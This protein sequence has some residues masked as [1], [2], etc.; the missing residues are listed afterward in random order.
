MNP[1]MSSLMDLVSQ[2]QPHFQTHQALLVIGMQNDFIQPEGRLPVSTKN[3]YLDRIQ[4]LIP[5]FRELNGNVIW[6]QTLYEG[7]R[8]ANDPNTGEGDALV[9]G[10]LVDGDESSTEGGEEDDVL[11]E[12]PTEKMKSP[13]KHKQ[14]ALDLL[15]RVSARR[16]TLPREVARATAEQDDELFLLAS[17]KKTPACV[18]NTHG[19]QFADIIAMQFELPADMVIKTSNYSAFQG[20]SLLMTLR[21]K[22]VTELYIC[23]CI[24]NIS[25]LATVIDAA[26]HGVKINVIED[27]LGYRKKGR[28]ELALK[29][30]DEFFDAYLVNST[31][32]LARERVPVPEK[33]PTSSNGS[34]NGLKDNERL[35]D[36]A[37]GR[38]SLRDAE[39]RPSS[40]PQSIRSPTKILTG[41]ER[42]LSLVSA[43]E[44]RKALNSPLSN[45]Q[46]V[47]PT[48]KEFTD[49]LVRGAIVPGADDGEKEE[50]KLVTKKIRMRSKGTKK[51]KK[52]KIDGDAAPEDVETV[53]VD[54]EAS[55]AVTHGTTE[56]PTPVP[57]TLQAS[58][59]AKSPS[60]PEPEPR[61]GSLLARAESVLNL[62]EKMTKQQPLKS[63]ASQPALSGK[64]DVKEKDK[65]RDSWSD[66][67]RQTLS[68]AP[69]SESDSR[70]R[71][72]YISTKAPSKAESRPESISTPI[73]QVPE[74]SSK[75]IDTTQ[76]E[77]A[78]AGAEEPSVSQES[79]ITASTLSTPTTMTATKT[80]P[81]KLQSLA[82]LPMLGPGDKI[83]EGD[84][85]IL[86]DFIP[87]DLKHPSEPIKPLRDV[88]FT[89][90]Y[91]EV[92]W[93]TMHHQTGAVP[94]LVCAQGLFGTDGS[95]PVY[96]HPSD[97]SLPLLHF[98]PKVEVIRRR[99]EKVVGHPLN[100]VLIQM[101]RDG[102]DYI[103]EHS[104]KTLDIVRG[105]SIVNVSFGAQRTMRL[106]TK[107]SST[108]PASTTDK[109]GEK[110][111]TEEKTRETQ[112]I[113]L[114]HNSIYSLG[115]A[116]NT[117]FLHS[118][119]PDK[120]IPTERSALELAYNGIRISLTFRHVGTFLDAR[121]NTIWGQG[122]TAREQRDAADVINN[123][124][125]E[126]EKLIHAFGT[127]NKSSSDFN[128]DSTYGTGFDVLHLHTAPPDLPI[129]FAS[130]NA[131]ETAQARLA[132]WEGKIQHE[133]IEA[134]ILDPE[135]EVDRQVSFRD[136]D[137]MHT[138]MH[139][140]SC[141]LMYLD[142]YYPFDASERN[143]EIT[144]NAYPT[145]LLAAGLLKAWNNRIVP[146][147]MTE[148]VS[149]L[150]QMEDRMVIQGGPF[151]AGK[152]F[153]V[154]DCQ[155]WPVVDELV[156]KWE[157]WSEE[158]Y[159]GLAEWY[160]M[161]WRKKGCVKKLREKLSEKKVYA[162]DVEKVEVKD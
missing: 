67:M 148:F 105:S 143:K 31:E 147:Y 120:R 74:L 39:G 40:R 111:E 7:D 5:K 113:P 92:H 26:R 22:L 86:H 157:G 108:T 1:Q 131:I 100:H 12:L 16:K 10:G 109:D 75:G 52:K 23:G 34:R 66:R 96:R 44:T 37:L 35:I 8:I 47:E 110:K 62:R 156:E 136:T 151:I 94:R 138:E 152:R 85:S 118:I 128:W 142:K 154:A 95:M 84:S 121:S 41:G 51:K 25:V 68:R 11:K 102:T 48:D 119:Q 159:P 146:T 101:Y 91:N 81:T 150:A 65:D 137:A 3:G 103:S 42:K 115:P 20:T 98:S 153:S 133:F 36:E 58:E 124:E 60:R 97:Q 93:Q 9:V 21:A 77:A 88:I 33:K 114:P 38:L 73:A 15:K 145:M 78:E 18:P 69:K 24:T 82:N 72:S 17:E 57:V 158:M 87:A 13:S 56:A 134:P 123:D 28:H 141:I 19:A 61:R 104:D 107:K 32:I 59:A 4:T 162:V 29:R 89:N 106:R 71:T 70:N 140:S 122:A 45:E 27:C 90:L 79:T 43:A 55:A 14:R 112:R 30:M 125:E 49:N 130:N 99:A 53:E 116:T 80:K 6:V 63:V 129:L 135:F 64:V 161:T 54:T 149:L 76:K 117:S 160:C 155:V 126:S 83:G 139:M 127:E 144:A 50:T 132:L 46:S 2:N